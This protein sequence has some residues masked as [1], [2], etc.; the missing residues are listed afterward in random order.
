[1]A[2]GDGRRASGRAAA[3]GIRHLDRQPHARPRATPS[4]PSKARTATAM[5]SSRPRSS[6]GAGLAVVAA[7]AARALCRR[8][9]VIGRARRARGLARARR[10]GAGPHA[11]QGDRRHRLGRQ[12]RNQGGVAAGAEQGRRDPRFGRVLQQSLGRAAVARALSGE[13]ALCGPG[14]GNESRRRDRAAVAAGA[15]ACRDHHHDC[16]GASRILRL[17]RQDR[18]RQGGDLSR[19]RSRRRRGA[20]SRQFAI[21]APEAPRQGS[22]RRAHRVVRRTRK[23]RRAPDQMRFA[24]RLLDRSGAKFS[25]PNSPTRSA[26]RAVISSTI[27]WRCWRRPCWSAPISRWR[28]WRSPNS[29]R[30]PDA[31]RAIEIDLPGGPALRHRRQLQCQSGF[32]RARRWRL[33]GQAPIGPRGRRIAVLGDMLELGPRGRALHR[34]LLEPVVANAVDLVF[35][36]GPL[37]RALVAGS[38]RQPPRRLCRGLRRAR[39]ASSVRDPCRRRRHGQGLARLAHGAH[40]Q[41]A[42]TAVGAPGHVGKLVESDALRNR[43]RTRLMRCSIGWSICRTR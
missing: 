18:R 32:R 11:S 29:S 28:R 14:N 8:R 43:V 26:R 33:L 30:Y 10:R 37:M 42:A 24:R 41:G 34:G 5:T 27:R 7:G 2:D 38:S 6:N 23:G 20:Q 35:C 21:R 15:P 16:A 3:I 17:A 25:A 1:M 31:A 40:R 9:A 4:S 36:C 19:P 12:D 13:R 39:G 22:G